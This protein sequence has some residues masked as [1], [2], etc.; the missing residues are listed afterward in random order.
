[1]IMKQL[2]YN[3]E[4]EEA[5]LKKG[6]RF[7]KKSDKSKMKGLGH[8]SRECLSR[9]CS[10]SKLIS[11]SATYVSSTFLLSES[12]PMWIVHYGST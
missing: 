1:M 5:N 7:F 2:K 11:L 10:I 8:F 6:K 9:K 12:Y 4:K 3:S